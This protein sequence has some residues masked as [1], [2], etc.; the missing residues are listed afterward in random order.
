[1]NNAIPFKKKLEFSDIFSEGRVKPIKW[2]DEFEEWS[3]EHQIR[4]A[5]ALASTMNEA[6]SAMQDDRNRCAIALEQATADRDQAIQAAEISKQ[7]MVQVVMDS[8]CKTRELEAEVMKL[9]E[10]LKAYE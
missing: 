1:M 7:T 3:L 5:K 10:R 6:A 4:Y 2:G 8:N 9:R